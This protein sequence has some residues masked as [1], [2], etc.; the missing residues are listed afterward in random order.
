MDR[1]RTAIEEGRL[2]PGSRLP[3]EKLARALDA[4]RARVREA[5]SLLASEHLVELQTNRGA[6]VAKPTVEEARYICE[7]R[8]MAERAMARLAAERASPE[9]VQQM[10]KLVAEEQDA[11]NIDKVS[12][13]VAKSR[14]FHLAIAEAAANPVLADILA[15]L[16]SRSALTQA[17]YATRGAAGCLCGDHSSLIDAIEA[18]D[19]DMAETIMERHIQNIISRLDLE[20]LVQEVDIEDALRNTL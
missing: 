14:H 18:G 9:A 8:I 7:A 6:F 10:R 13:A 16:L 4:S 1:L 12:S 3:E 2:P 5:L 19:P 15:S 17:V 11:W 20:P